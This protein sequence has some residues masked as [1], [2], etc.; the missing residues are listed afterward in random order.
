MSISKPTPKVCTLVGL[1]SYESCCHFMQ[2]FLE[3]RD[4]LGLLFF[5]D[6]SLFIYS[7]S[8]CISYKM[9]WIVQQVGSEKVN[10][11]HDEWS[12]LK[13][14]G[15]DTMMNLTMTSQ[16]CE[17]PWKV[18]WSDL[19]VTRSPHLQT[20]ACQHFLIISGRHLK[21][22]IP[23]SHGLHGSCGVTKPFP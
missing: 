8:T 20:K 21:N 19:G 11:N 12:W 4:T 5:D 22:L 6:L 1:F 7:S 14:R 15:A 13:G 18:A 2:P 3:Q 10:S 17:I 9:V 23:G 16:I